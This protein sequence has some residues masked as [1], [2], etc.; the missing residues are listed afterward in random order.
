MENSWPAVRMLGGSHEQGYWP[1]QQMSAGE[2][3]K[4]CR[5]AYIP[6]TRQLIPHMV[7]TRKRADSYSSGLNRV[8][9]ASLIPLLQ[10][11]RWCD[12]FFSLP[13]EAGINFIFFFNPG[14]LFC[15]YQQDELR[16]SSPL[17]SHNLIPRSSS[18]FF[19]QKPNPM[20]FKHTA[21]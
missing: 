16:G 2:K 4:S 11:R 14:C 21:S 6:H 20:S 10:R 3:K 17:T 19:H 13:L 5:N 12:C 18:L 7:K 1:S 8:I 15:R 9:S